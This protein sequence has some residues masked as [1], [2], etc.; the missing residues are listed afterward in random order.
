V[1]QT[2]FLGDVL[3]RKAYVSDLFFPDTKNN[4]EGT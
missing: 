1:A 2:G 4:I 3:W